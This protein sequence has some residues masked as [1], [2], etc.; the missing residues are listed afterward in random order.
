[1]R[2]FSR[3]F[4]VVLTTLSLSLTGENYIPYTC[5]L[6]LGYDYFRSL[7]EGDWEGNTGGLVSINVGIPAPYLIGV[8]A[9]CLL[10]Y[11]I[12]AQIGGSYG[13]YDWS[14]RG[15]SPSGR[16][17]RAQQQAFLTGAI[18]RRTPCCSG[19]NVG[20]AYDWMWN[21]NAS[22][23]ALQSSIAQLRFQGGYICDQTDE[24]GIWGTLDVHTSHRRSEGIP[25]SFRAISQINV[26]WEHRFENCART[27]LWAGIPYKKS[28]MFSTGRAGKFILGGCFHA[29]LTDRLSIDG[30][31]CYMKGHSASGALKQRYSAANLCI[32]LKWAFGD[33]ECGIE[34]YMPI[35]NNSNFITDTNITF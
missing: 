13:V 14:G 7:P 34:P 33:E 23:F 17:T 19:I 9:Q 35:G 2:F 28:L 10:D 3:F 1:M 24:W 18:S 6:G 25:V 5:E 12:N 22:V 11:G 8:P 20:L 31:A 29:P 26:Y 30:H 16:Q 4:A 27:M 15:S 32:E 21:K